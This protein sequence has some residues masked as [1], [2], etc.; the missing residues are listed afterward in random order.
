DCLI[1]WRAHRNRADF[2]EIIVDLGVGLANTGLVSRERADTVRAGAAGGVV[3]VERR[4]LVPWRQ[5]MR[6]DMDIRPSMR[7]LHQL[8]LTR[9]TRVVG[10][11]ERGLDVMLG[12]VS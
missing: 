12:G 8:D 4:V 1:V 5:P 11:D 2:V 7:Q 6:N 10:R 9:H 3:V